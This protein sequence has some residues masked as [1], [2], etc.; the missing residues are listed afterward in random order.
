MKKIKL[1]VLM[2]VLLTFPMIQNCGTASKG[3]GSS[4]TIAQDLVNQGW[5]EIGIGNYKTAETLFQQALAENNTEAIRISAN[6]G[7]GWA[8]S[9]NGKILESIPYFEA[10]A[11]SDN[12]A[13]VGLCGAL[14][15][16]HQTTQDY[17]KAAEML[18]NMPPEKF[19]QI[20]SGLS[21]SSAKVHALAALA[22]ALAG[23]KE[24]ANTY[25]NKAAALDSMMVGTGVDK[26]DDAFFLL[27][28][29]D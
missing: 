14:I 1:L 6:N 7:M 17:V 11:I 4:Y 24:K 12:E 26:L 23:D 9:K 5:D 22:Y 29:K 8:L 25:I 28:W 10:A 21:L 20:H 27:G 13:V 2:V 19:A 15:Y 16:R 18:G 3:G